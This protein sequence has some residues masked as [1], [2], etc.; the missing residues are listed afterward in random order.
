[1]GDKNTQSDLFK[2][3]PVLSHTGLADL[4]LQDVSC[5]PEQ[6]KPFRGGVLMNKQCCLC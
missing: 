6:M 2:S 5:G 1:M 3:S 4:T